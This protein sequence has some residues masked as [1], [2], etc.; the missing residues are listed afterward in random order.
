MRII[1]R[2]S[3]KGRPESLWHRT[4][5]VLDRQSPGPGRLNLR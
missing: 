3:D 2:H 4:P 5:H 1:A